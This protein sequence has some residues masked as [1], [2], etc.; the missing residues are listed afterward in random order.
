MFNNAG[1]MFEHMEIKESIYKGVVGPFCKKPA[2]EDDN[3]DGHNRNI[4]EKYPRLRL[5]LWN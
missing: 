4:E 5:T 3:R 2:R 1:N